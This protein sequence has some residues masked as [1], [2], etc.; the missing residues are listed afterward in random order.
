MTSQTVNPE[1]F[2]QDYLEL[3]E[4]LDQYNKMLAK[5]TIAFTN[6]EVRKIAGKSHQYQ[7]M[8]ARKREYA[9]KQARVM[10]PEDA[11]AFLHPFLKIGQNKSSAESI[12][13][14]R[15]VRHEIN[16]KKKMLVKKKKSKKSK[17]AQHSL[18]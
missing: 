3:V 12:K 8:L 7:Q 14:T 2:L 10:K 11:L 15:R 4:K 1:V 6:H 18:L 17:K 16:T 13:F 9:M 5:K